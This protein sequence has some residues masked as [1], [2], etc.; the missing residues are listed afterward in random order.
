MENKDQDFDEIEFKRKGQ[1]TQNLN[2]GASEQMIEKL[3]DEELKDLVE[4]RFKLIQMTQQIKLAQLEFDNAE[5]R[6]KLVE[7]VLTA[8]YALNKNDQIILETGVITRS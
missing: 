1:M 7:F 5:L 4:K 3:S 6:F 2:P 8:K